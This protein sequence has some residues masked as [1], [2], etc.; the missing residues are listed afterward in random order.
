MLYQNVSVSSY[1]KLIKLDFLAVK[2]RYLRCRV[3]AGVKIFSRSR[4]VDK[5]SLVARISRANTAFPRE[6]CSES[7]HHLRWVAS[8]ACV[9]PQC[10][11]ELTKN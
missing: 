10:F 2:F 3:S 5:S 1:E 7:V 6:S 11:S 4:S 9:I 8:A